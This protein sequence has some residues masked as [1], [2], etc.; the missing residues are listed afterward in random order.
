[1]HGL[2]SSAC[3]ISCPTSKQ[4]AEGSCSTGWDRRT[5]NYRRPRFC[6]Q[7]NKKKNFFHLQSLQSLIYSLYSHSLKPTEAHRCHN[8]TEVKKL[9]QTLSLQNFAPEC[10][11][12]PT[13]SDALLPRQGMQY[14]VGTGGESRFGDYWW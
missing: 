2:P 12:A 14:S 13:L 4:Q 5:R 3:P 9:Q 10:R 7:E 8:H 11:R 1:L 6:T